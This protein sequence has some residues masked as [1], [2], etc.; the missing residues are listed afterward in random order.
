MR[1]YIFLLTLWSMFLLSIAKV[2]RLLMKGKT[3]RTVQI[4]TQ[5][6]LAENLNVKVDGS[7]CYNNDP[8]NCEKYGRLYEWEAAKKV[9]TMIPGWHLPTD[10]EWEKLCESLDGEKHP[11][12]YYVEIGK[13]LQ[14]G[15]ST[16]L[17]LVLGGR[18]N[19]HLFNNF[20]P[21]R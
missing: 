6:W 21:S 15:G 5:C 12:G 9:A 1:P 14:A 7:S 16:G 13:V 2:R 4:G 20:E 10:A 3:Y 19:N 8:T 11:Q 17:D 18:H